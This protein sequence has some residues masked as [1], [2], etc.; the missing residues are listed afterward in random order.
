MS[1]GSNIVS[2]HNYSLNANG[3]DRISIYT[4]LF[5][6]HNLKYSKSLTNMDLILVTISLVLC[7]LRRWNLNEMKGRVALLFEDKLF[8]NCTNKRELMFFSFLRCLI[9]KHPDKSFIKIAS[10]MHMRLKRLS[11]YRDRNTWRV[12]RRDVASCDCCPVITCM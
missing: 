7:I 2:F 8:S 9:E 5:D 6:F 1:F 12:I 3:A 10:N 11:I 4:Q